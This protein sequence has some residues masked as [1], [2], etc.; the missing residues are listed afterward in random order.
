MS[1]CSAG[2][3][4]ARSKPRVRPARSNSAG[5]PVVSAAAASSIVCVSSGSARTWPMNCSSI[6][7]PPERVRQRRVARELQGRELRAELEHRERVAAGLGRDLPRNV[8]LD[9]PAGDAFQ[10]PRSLRLGETAEAHLGDASVRHALAVG[11]A[12]RDDEPDAVRVEAPGDEGEH[13]GRF[14]VEPLPRRRRCTT[15]AGA[16]PRSTV[17]SASPARRASRRHWHLLRIRMRPAAPGVD[18]A[19][20]CRGRRR[21]DA[22]GGAARRIRAPS[23]IRSR[24]GA[25]PADPWPTRPSRRATRSCRSRPRRATPARH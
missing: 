12:H 5:S 8:A 3:A 23:R 24:R 6:C 11:I 9:R 2:S 4:E 1:A 25:A 22:E 15:G 19:G 13:V 14:A 7:R 17:P 20:A 16:Q 18:G 10:Q 21:R